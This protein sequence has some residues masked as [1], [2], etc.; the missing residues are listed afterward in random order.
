MSRKQAK[1][2]HLH[3]R[4]SNSTTLDIRA[5]LLCNFPST[6]DHKSQMILCQ[7]ANIDHLMFGVVT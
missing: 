3:I 2:Y 6:R 1:R 4:N 5:V 7:L